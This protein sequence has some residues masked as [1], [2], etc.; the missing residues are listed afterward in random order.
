[1]DPAKLDIAKA[2]TCTTCSFTEDKSN[3]WTA[4]LY[5]KARNGTYKRVGQSPALNGFTGAV[6]GMTVYYMNDALYNS[7]PTTKVTAFKPGFRMFVGDPTYKTKE[8]AMNFRQ[9]T[10]TCMQNSGTRGP[11]SLSF[12]TVA[13]PY[14]LMVNVR[15]PTCWD[16][17]TL[18]AADHMSHMAYP[19]N[20]TFEGGAPCPATHSVKVP[21]VLYETIWDVKP[22]NDKSMW[23]TDGSQP[24]VWSF[25][26]Q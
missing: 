9:I 11:E 12:P 16:G 19:E 23:P 7:K 24:F 25:G 4:V 18:D 5:F 13:C 14:G 2:A 1:M 21:Q 15:F 8:Q 3:Y 22:F 26:D 6:G 17:K 10:Y 20:G